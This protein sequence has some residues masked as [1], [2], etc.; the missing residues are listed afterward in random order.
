MALALAVAGIG[1]NNNGKLYLPLPRGKKLH[2]STELASEPS[3]NARANIPGMADSEDAL[4]RPENFRKG[5]LARPDAKVLQ[6]HK[7][8]SF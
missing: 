5:L 4:Q 2:L 7:P 8:K 3:Y 1:K 6:F